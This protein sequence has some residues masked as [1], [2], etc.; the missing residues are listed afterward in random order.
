MHINITTFLNQLG[1]GIAG[2]NIVKALTRAG[3]E[4]ALWVNGP[5]GCPQEDRA[6][7]EAAIARS[8]T[9]DPN[10]PSL[11]ISHQWDM[12]HRV[13]RGTHAGLTFFELTYLTQT[14]RHH[15][16]S[17]DLVCVPTVWAQYVLGINGIPQ[18]KI[19]RVPLGVDPLI[20]HPGI[21][22]G[23]PPG[24]EAVERVIEQTR[25][26]VFF[27]CGKWEIRK[28]HDVLVEAFTRAFAPHENVLLVMNCSNPFLTKSQQ[29]EWVSL[30]RSSAF[31]CGKVIVLPDRLPRQQD[32]ARLMMLADCGVFPARAEG[33]NLELLEMLAMGKACIATNY[34]AHTEF[35]TTE[36]C[37]LVEPDG[38]EP[39]FDGVFFT[40]GQG[41]WAEL[42]ERAMEQL[43]SHLRDVHRRKQEGSLS[44]NMA[45]IQTAG[46]FT[47]DATAHHLLTALG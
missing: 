5:G 19:R 38:L 18:D 27:N 33:W 21:A 9:Y 39:A 41:Q 23:L 6:I 26:T 40:S 10:A 37:L 22:G 46:Q 29:E 16:S 32:V 15:L 28:G 4:P 24:Y 12:A 31:L 17:L 36:N 34:S 25:P 1:Y 42:G 30:Y 13:G 44:A 8:Q 2:L 43:V 47:W 45:G 11:R 35:C 3:H 14:E 20:F 7:I